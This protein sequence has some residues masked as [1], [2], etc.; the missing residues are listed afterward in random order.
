MNLKIMNYFLKAI[1]LLLTIFIL[2][3]I[4]LFNFGILI[5]VSIVIQEIVS[6]KSMI[7]LLKDIT[8]ITNIFWFGICI[9]LVGLYYIYQVTSNLYLSYIPMV[10]MV[11]YAV[12]NNPN[13]N[14]TY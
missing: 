1:A 8:K 7:Y 4:D 5:L 13:K 12:I 9:S 3:E 10:F 11:V 14:T 2:G 6:H